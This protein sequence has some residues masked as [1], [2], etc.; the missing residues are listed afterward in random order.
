MGKNIEFR[1][2]NISICAFPYLFL[3][4]VLVS[5]AEIA[6]EIEDRARKKQQFAMP[7]VRKFH[8]N[9]RF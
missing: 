6:T 5:L 9:M 8:M 2:G 7:V 1:F 4:H 3:V